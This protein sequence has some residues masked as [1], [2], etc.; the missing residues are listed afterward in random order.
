[1]RKLISVL[2]VAAFLS[3]TAWAVETLENFLAM[4]FVLIPA[5]E[6]IMGTDP[7]P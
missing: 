4:R 3:S 6:Y 2:A 1:M 5:G 7:R